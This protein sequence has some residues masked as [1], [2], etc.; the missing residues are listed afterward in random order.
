VHIDVPK[1]IS[2]VKSGNIRGAAEVV[3]S[4]N[5]LANVCGKVCPEEVY[6][7][8]VCDR[9]KMD[10]PIQIR[11][12]HFFATQHEA[13][14]GYSRLREFNK[15]GKK[16]AVIGGGPAG[17]GC[18]FELSKLGIQAT[19]FDGV[20]LGGVPRNSIP[21]FRLAEKELRDDVDFLSTHFEFKKERVDAQ[22]FDLITKQFGAVFI[23]IGLG[24]DRALGIKGE[25]LSGATHVLPF[26]EE[27]KAHP[28]RTLAGKNVI[29][30]G[31]GN[32]SLDAA[33]TAKRL[34]AASVKL[35]Y[36]RSER[37][38]RVW[39]SELN[40]ARAQGVEIHFLITPVEVL[41]TE[42]VSGVLCRRMALSDRRDSTGRL[43]PVEIAGSEHSLM[44]D[45]VIAAI[46]QE[47]PRDVF[48][49]LKRTTAGYLSVNEHFMTSEQGVFAGG[50]AINGEGTIVQSVAHG[51]QA[52]WE[53]HEYLKSTVTAQVPRRS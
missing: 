46:G 15:N 16:V 4:F 28:E 38:M 40:E 5:A 44:A 34:G 12:L 3:K 39:K 24:R 1:F 29:V 22:M 13:K 23:S 47:I 35:I 11:E 19:I 27:A 48:S 18:A 32:V 45:T 14:N 17:L 30:V 2:M 43:V 25:S 42:R 21:S 20:G 33:A 53:M 26:L 36:R 6:C 9:A 7:Q 31:G 52:A 37:E 8:S 10:A 50:D 41:G 49:H 51:K